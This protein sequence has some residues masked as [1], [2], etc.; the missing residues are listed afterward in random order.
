MTEPF[1]SKK[2]TGLEEDGSSR[3]ACGRAWCGPVPGSSESARMSAAR[4][5]PSAQTRRGEGRGQ[6]AL[7]CGAGIAIAVWG[8]AGSLARKL[9]SVDRACARFLPSSSPTAATNHAAAGS[10]VGAASIRTH[11]RWTSPFPS[12]RNWY[13]PPFLSQSTYLSA[14]YR[15]FCFS[16]FMPA[17]CDGRKRNRCS[18][19]NGFCS[20]TSSCF[21][22]RPTRHTCY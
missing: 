1:F 21:K 2:K 7:T 9:G 3:S 18:S 5:W 15:V 16:N 17:A 12:T 22:W 20:A 6:A 19:F 4:P 10:A 11:P 13:A 8:R 14:R